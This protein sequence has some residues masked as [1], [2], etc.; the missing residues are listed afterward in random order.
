[1]KKLVLLFSLT[2]ASISVFSQAKEICNNGIDDDFDGF[3]DCYDGSCANDPLCDGI[4]LGNDA[5]CQAPPP[6]FPKFTMKLDFA[7]PN[8]TTNHLSR[9]AVGDL[10]RDGLPEIVTMNRYTKTLYILNGNDGS[11]KSQATVAWEPY[12]EIAIANLDDDKCAEIFFIGYQDLAGSSNDGV[13]LFSYDCNLNLIWTTAKRLPSDPIN[14]GIADFDSDGKEELYAKDEIYDAKTGTR[15]VKTSAASYTKINGGPVA[16]NMVGSTDL[17]LVLGLNIYQVNLGARTADAG[18]LTLLKNRSEYFIRDEYNATSVADYNLDGS[19]DVLASGSTIA[20]DQNTTLFF[21][22]VKNDT[23]K[24]YSDPQPALGT[25]Y[26]N[27]WINGTGRLNIADLDGNGKMNASFVSG[28]FLYALDEKF[29]LLW[30]VNINEETSGYTGCTLFDFNGDGKAEIVYRDERFLYIIEGTDGSIYSQQACISRT[31]REYP[32]VADVDADGSTELC[33]TCGFSDK[34][35]SKNFGTLSYSRYAHVRVFKSAAEPW[36]PARRVWNQHGYFVVNVNDDL[37]IPKI[38]Q[39]HHLIFS[40]GSCTQGPNRPLNKFLN[41]SPY[42][43]S[44]G[45]PTYASAD[46]A[47]SVAPT[48]IP[49]TCPNLDFKV[50]FKIT[51][52]GDVSI[53]GDIPVTFYTTNPK[54][55]GAVKLNTITASVSHLA[56]GDIF[57]VTNA[58]VTGIGSDSLYVVLNDAGTTV[59]TPIKLPNTSFFECDYDNVRGVKVNPLPAKL[60]ALRVNHNDNCSASNKGVARAFVPVTGGENT[61]DY[62]F[63]WS[64]GTTAK[65][66]A[67]ADNVGPVYSGLG[68]GTYTVYAIHKTAKCNSDTVQVVINT[69]TANLSAVTINI[70]SNQTSCTPLNGKLEAVMS[71]GGAGYKFEWFDIGLNP[72]N[73][74]GPVASNLAAGAYAVVVTRGQCQISATAVISGPSVPDA[75]ATVVSDVVD[76]TNPN[77]GSINATGI[78]NG[79]VQDPAN[80]TFTWYK[81]NNVTSTQESPLLPAF[82]TGPTRTGLPVGYYQVE[83]KENTSQCVSTVK[84]IVQVKSNLVTPDPPQ[85]SI[86]SSQTSCDPLKPN[87]V[88]TAEVTIGGVAQPASD[89]TFEWFKGQ[90]TLAANKVNTVSDV[91]GKTVNQV[92]GGGTPY[93]VRVT[94]AFHCSATADLAIT[95][96]IIKPVITLSQLTPNTVCDPTKASTPYNGSL[97]VSVT[98]GGSPVSLPD[99]NYEFTWRN[100]SNQIIAVTDAKNPILSGVA[101]GN[102]YSVTVERKDIFCTS[103]ADNEPVLKATILPKLTTSSTGSN[104]CNAALTPDGTATVTVTNGIAGDAFTFT[105]FT[106]NTTGG[107]QLSVVNNNGNQATAIK[108]GGPVSAPNPY[109]VL[110]LNTKTGCEN[111]ATQFVADNSSIPVISFVNSTPNTICS[112]AANFNGS[113][114]TKVDNQI[115]VITDYVFT[116]YNGKTNAA[117][118]K[119]NSSA[120]VI[121]GKLKQGFYTV[122]TTN[123]KTGCKSSAITNQVQDGRILPAI[124]ITST[125]SNNCDPLLTP[126]G[127]ITATVTNGGTNFNYT[128]S[129]VAP[130]KAITNAANNAN[131][132]TAIKV[133]GPSNA[134]NSYKVVVV[135]TNNGCQSNSTG[136][137]ADVSAKP[138][139]TLKAFPNTVCALIP[140]GPTTFTGHID[141]TAVNHPALGASALTYQWFNAD[142]AG[143]ITGP[144][145]T[146]TTS[147][148]TK[149]DIGKFGVKVTVNNLGCTSDV[150]VDEVLRTLA[151]F[152]V[153]THISPSTN[154]APV[155]PNGLAEVTAPVGGSFQ[156]QWYDGSLINA[157][158]LKAGKTSALLA[159]NIQGGASSN[160]AV[161]VTN[162]SDGCQNNAAVNVPDGSVTPTLSLSVVKNNTVCNI[163]PIDPDGELLATVANAGGNFSITWTGGIAPATIAGTNGEQFTKLRAGSY[164]AKV[165]N[166]I[167]GCVSTT[168]TKVITDNLTFPAVSVAID[169]Q[170][171]CSAT[172][173]GRLAV[174]AVGGDTYAWFDGVGTATA[175]TPSAVTTISQLPS[176]DYTVQ[177]TTTTTGCKT[178]KSNFVPENISYPLVT[179]ANTGLVTTCGITPNGVATTSITGLIGTPAFASIKYDIFYVFTADGNTFPTDE[180]TLRASS[181]KIIDGTSLPLANHSGLAPG[182]LTAFAVDKNTLCESVIKTVQIVDAVKNYDFTIDGKTKAGLCGVGGG[183]IEVT[184]ERSDNPGVPCATCSYSWYK[185]TPSNSNINFF[186]NP[187][188]MSSATPVVAPE[189][190]N[191]DLG[192]PAYGP[193]VFTG[194]YTLVVLDTDPT[195]KDCGNYMTDFVSPA[196]LPNVAHT[197]TPNTN[198]VTP[199]GKIDVNVSGGTSVLGYTI[200]IFKGPNSLGALVTQLAVPAKP[201]LLSTT[202]TLD[203]GEYFIEVVDNDA[204]NISCPFGEGVRIDQ[205]VLPPI[206]SLSAV[207]ANSSCDPTTTSDGSVTILVN[208]AAG[209]TGPAKNYRIESISPAVTG[210]A[211]P[212]VVGTGATGQSEIISGLKPTN[213]VITVRDNG[214]ACATDLSVTI[215]NVQD[216]PDVLTITPT[217]ETMCSNVSNGSAL[218]SIANTLVTDLD[219]FDFTWSQNNDL[220]GVVYAAAGNG[221]GTAGELLNRTHATASTPG[222]FW[223]MGGAGQ[224]SGNRIYYAQGVKNATSLTGV[225]CKTAVVQIVISDQ[226]VTPQLT[227]TPTAN[228][229]CNAVNVGDIGDAQINIAADANPALAGN[230]NSAGGFNYSWTNANASL[231]TPQN[232]KPNLFTIPGLGSGSSVVTATNVDNGCVA[233]KTTTVKSAPYFI[234][235]TSTTVTDQLIC[236]PNGQIDVKQIVLDRSS[237]GLANVTHTSASPLT[238]VYDFKWF[239][240][241]PGNP[242]TFI[243]TPLKDVVGPTDINRQSLV[244]GN[245]VGQYVP[246]GAG[247]YYVKA[248]RKTGS[249][250]AEGCN[251]FPVRVDVKDAH[252]NPVVNLTPFSNNSCL[253]GTGNGEI[254]IRVSDL[255]PASFG[256]VFSYDYDWTAGGIPDAPGNDGD[257]VSTDGDNDREINLLTGVYTL[258]VINP[259]S[260]CSS[261]ATTEI[262][263]N[264]TPIFVQNVV[265][266]DQ[267]NCDPN[268]DGSLN[269]VTI[270]LKDRNGVTQTINSSSNISD[271][272]FDW[273]RS[274]NAF[275]QTTP[276]TLLNVVNYNTAGFGTPI[277]AGTYAVIARRIAG[278]PGQPGMG[279]A[280][281]PFE[282]EILDKRI[283]PVVKLTPLA[284]TSCDPLLPE[285]TISV[286]IT[287]A[288]LVTGPYTFSYTWDNVGDPTPIG[289]VSTGVN[290]GDGSGAD[291]DEDNP[292]GLLQGVYNLSVKNN[293]SLCQ[294][295]A[296]TTIL[297]NSTPIFIPQATA[298]PQVLCSAD[299]SLTVAGVQLTDR[300]G[301]SQNPP[302]ADF[303]FAWSRTTLAN[304]IAN[305]PGSLGA[306][307]GGLI[308]DRTVYSQ[309]GAD[310]YFIVAKRTAGNLGRGC[311]S[312]PFRIEI[313]D[314]R[315]FPEVAF[316]T[317]PNSACSPLL[318]NGTVIV[319]AS[320]RNGSSVGPYTFGWSLNGSPVGAPATQTNTSNSSTLMKAIDGT[321]L[322]TAT[323]SITS[324]PVVKTFILVSDP[325]GSTPNVIEVST[326][327]PLDCNP[328]GSAAVT[329]ITLGSVSTSILFPPNVPPN[330]VVSGPALNSFDFEWYKASI[331]VGNQLPA[332]GPFITTP[333]ISSLLPGNYYVVVHD[334]I[335]DCRSGGREVIIKNDKIIYPVLDVNQLAKQVNCTTTSGSASLEA[336]ADGQTD[337]N[338]NYSFS[339]FNNSTTTPPAIFTTSKISNLLAG[340]Y[341]VS[342]LDKT[343]SCIATG[344]Y[345]VQDE[346]ATFTPEISMGSQPRTLCVG[347]DGLIEA[348][349]LNRNALYPY[350]Y[351]ALTFT[352]DLY[353]GS[354]PDLSKSPDMPAIAFVKGS[355]SEFTQGNLNEG[356]YTVRIKDN[357][358]GCF[359]SATEQI[360]DARKFPVPEITEIAPVTNCYPTNPNGVARVISDGTFSGYRFEWYEGSSVSG[361]PFYSGSEYSKLKVAPQ[362]YTVRVT[363]MISGCATDVHTT[364]KDGSLPIPAP[365]IEVLSN[366]TSCII[367][368]GA[369]SS[370]VGVD[371][372]TKDYTFSWYDGEKENPPADFIGEIYTGLDDG[373]YAVT[374]TSLVTG[375]KSP[376]VTGEI[377]I[378]QLFPE[379]DFII[380]NTSCDQSDGYATLILKSDVPIETIEWSNSTG[381][382]L[383]GPNYTGATAGTYDVTVTTFMGCKSEKTVEIKADIRPYN[384]ISR[385]NDGRNEIFQ[386]DC[387]QNFPSN[388]V[389]VFNRAGTLVYEG[390]G[391]DNSATYFDGKS[392]KGISPMGVNLPDGTYFYI[393]DKGDGS[394][395]LAGYLE[396]VK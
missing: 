65:P 204:V 8:E 69:V 148:L 150:V 89:F 277:G 218:V 44:E 56:K 6:Q 174:A 344:N 217:P 57:S 336:I 313:Q 99:N 284:N 205:T 334:P 22:D 72:L 116:W 53:T 35:A 232:A 118:S 74:L 225:G 369:L 256:P 199:N 252:K 323:N 97:Q 208:N 239:A 173:N 64:N 92:A 31:N 379:F 374:A 146:S 227:L 291:G 152:T 30:R 366:L 78:L 37:T 102:S 391:Y 134:P 96:N 46:I 347:T 357:N 165:T 294:S 383:A 166:N 281:A 226:H 71:D 106:G 337:A 329:K 364:I 365:E 54:R 223:P 303:Q 16:I 183:G 354:T 353:F 202:A 265:S 195:H 393:V 38:V 215:P 41:Q 241:T 207:A 280:S 203:D 251:S 151:Q 222:N 167:T 264:A 387:I 129:A 319:K 32:I 262:L 314:K 66:I 88:M 20:Y 43:N 236:N 238:S 21:W 248:T 70:L 245:G 177:A 120:T 322:L 342:V 378:D 7:S 300:N 124:S 318:A 246:M 309:I 370:Y 210:Y 258:K 3:I 362:Q 297:K 50:S 95:E 91:N 117:G 79:V 214:S 269:V 307:P 198:C 119:N 4:F 361:A 93:T 376:L 272:Q 138:T 107:S 373:K 304:V 181:D 161:L 316:T 75:Q 338:A 320:E 136:Q 299:G 213:Y 255:T 149:L 172:P 63:Y 286:K 52:L 24:T 59:P 18:S 39:P 312:A 178:V 206:V 125:G 259:A 367:A 113:L 155:A 48:I 184:V 270:S 358:T 47:F 171:S 315:L 26:T 346:S 29:K 81:Y 287:D 396:I 62:N 394:K 186:N 333:A 360:K 121:L 229:F 55:A 325:T 359:G 375:C 350:P 288:T 268:G 13:Y 11:I 326:V 132:Q 196:S 302:V 257:G 105:W 34:D 235:I 221:L 382:F 145:P 158:Q 282:V 15:I 305:T 188:N 372:N 82:G 100:P 349:V 87:G 290:D 254:E 137:V 194:T 185:G 340:N 14:F 385:N 67:S 1:M 159:N 128:W 279:C 140:G 168:D 36:V 310:N 263:K 76:C 58:T 244:T 170:T 237:A 228:S 169:A 260:G 306:V 328:T 368:N 327:D 233:T 162:L 27:G 352:A 332:G 216:V 190:V 114:E 5:T 127:T 200:K 86:L 384:G 197:L 60:T 289:T 343:T 308:L 266:V 45:C 389:K 324:C 267:K 189:A 98:F 131:Q 276:G 209:D 377:I 330:N 135:N 94:N 242:N 147:S 278:A 28:R 211:T 9:M 68:A 348:R 142:N 331:A 247:T 388:I 108:L 182:Y 130:A 317:T 220:T 110:V 175:H 191:E 85:I 261:S 341:S 371:R 253:V 19:L 240:A 180:A 51:N 392:N 153:T 122:E 363:E 80:Y 193:G 90:N 112:P 283:F 224:G 271:F 311:S 390:H 231:T 25:D 296:V 292:T 285:G 109:T 219:E 156:Y 111:S 351:N 164:D 49:P 298:T 321:Y 143:T 42:L 157:A 73:I 243:N 234:S 123:S 23:I 40:T 17:E 141:V 250:E 101:D 274:G 84:P 144:N 154:C 12:W 275:T 249:G 33:V 77:S 2:I 163:G 395:P 61:A 133:G 103:L 356:F 160:F 386:I 115:G 230:Q 301:V 139:V 273:T 83:V 187:P 126:D 355:F 339:W 176:G 380:Q 293:Q 10:D 179:L 201:A 104:N 345:V 212:N 381:P 295:T 335:T 192:A